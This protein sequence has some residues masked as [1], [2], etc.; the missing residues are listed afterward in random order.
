MTELIDRDL[1]GEALDAYLDWRDECDAVWDACDW[2]AHAS[3]SDAP[4]AVSAYLTALDREERAANVYADAITRIAGE[5]ENGGEAPSAAQPVRF[6][7]ARW[8]R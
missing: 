4:T 6:W 5:L 3:A 7:R 8:Q 1:V 2:W